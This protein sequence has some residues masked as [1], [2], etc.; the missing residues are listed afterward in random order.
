MAKLVHASLVP[1]PNLLMGP[2]L[3]YVCNVQL[4]DRYM[5]LRGPICLL[6]YIKFIQELAQLN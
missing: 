3:L 6:T 5:H 1:P 4:P 2:H